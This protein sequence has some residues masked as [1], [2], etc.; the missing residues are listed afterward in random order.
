MKI[1]TRIVTL[2][3]LVA[4]LGFGLPAAG[5]AFAQGNDVEVLFTVKPPDKA[6]EKTK[7]DAPQIEATIIGAPNLP[8]DKFILTDASAK[9]P[10]ALKAI[11]KREYNKG[12]ETLA[13]A[14]VMNGWEMWIGNDDYLPEDDPSRYPGVLNG[15]RTALDKVNFGNAGPPGSVGT[16]IVYDDSVSERVKMGPLANITGQSLG[17]QKDYQNTQG[18]ELYAGV[19]LGV[20]KLTQTPASRKV[21]IVIC[22]GVDTNVDGAKAQFAALKKL[23]QAENIQTFAI[24]YRSGFSASV[25]GEMGVD[26]ISSLVK[27]PQT[28]NG[29]DAIGSAV[30]NILGRMNDRQYFTFPGYDKK[31]KQGLLWDGKSHE[32][33]I[34]YEKEET[35]SVGVLLQ[36]VWS[37]APPAGFPWLILI[38]AL[39]GL[40]LLIVI[41]V[42]VFGGKPA[43]APVVA[44]PVMAAMPEAPKPMGPVKTVMFS[45]GGDADGFPIVGW[46]VAINGPNAFQTFRLRSGGTKIGTAHPSDIVVNDGFMSTEH[47]TI[48][49]APT[50]FTLIDPG[51]TNGCYV[52]DRRVQKQDLVDNDTVTLGKTSFKFKSIN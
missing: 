50:G 46:L 47:C 35:P 21:L 20:T 5:P 30:E 34:K 3:T 48:H 41:G 42:K 22:D 36:P 49:C 6:N 38:L 8:Q 28:V 9:L 51:S 1:T 19:Y 13:L 29:A 2:V 33:V 4:T 14:I 45:A 43:P 16:I 7:D 37:N 44:A 31:T 17:T 12:T 40:L 18:R 52:N 32:L 10:V 26:V 27:N 24:I 39:V 15:L 25:P 23:T 11:S